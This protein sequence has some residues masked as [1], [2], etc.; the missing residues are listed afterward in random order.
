MILLMAAHNSVQD[1]AARAKEWA[2][3]RV[4]MEN[5]H[6]QSQFT[7]VGRSEEQIQFSDQYPQSADF[8]YVD[9]QQPPFPASSYQQ[10]PAPAAPAPQPPVA[11]QQENA[12][13]S[14]G[15]PSYGPDVRLPYSGRDGAS[16]GEANVGFPHQESSHTSPSVHQQ[17]VPSSYSSVTGNNSLSI[18]NLHVKHVLKNCFYGPH[19]FLI[20]CISADTYLSMQPFLDLFFR[21]SS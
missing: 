1:W 12:S 16:A 4:A 8:H 11:Y 21:Q 17:E 7:S 5:Q 3:A 20:N 18:L 2:N 10:F 13:I 14:S 19:P 6:T 9:T 15:L